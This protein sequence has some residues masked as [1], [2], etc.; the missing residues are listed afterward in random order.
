M[1]AG[2]RA[3]SGTGSGRTGR[4]WSGAPITGWPR[5]R[6]GLSSARTTRPWTWG[7]THIEMT[8]AAGRLTGM[9]S[10]QS[11]RRTTPSGLAW[12]GTDSTA[13]QPAA[14][15]A[16]IRLIGRTSPVMTAGRGIPARG[17]IGQTTAVAAT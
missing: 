13:V 8:G 12:I 4:L 9:G 15:T 2:A 17:P 14:A 1:I 7:Q 6:S 10:G 5:A 3:W 16:L 11:G